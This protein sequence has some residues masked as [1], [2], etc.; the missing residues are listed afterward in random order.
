MQICLYLHCDNVSK[1]NRMDTARAQKFSLQASHWSSPNA[2]TTCDLLP[3]IP[4]D[5]SKEPIHVQSGAWKLCWVLPGSYKAQ[6]DVHD[7]L[8]S[9]QEGPRIRSSGIDLLWNA[10]SI[11]P[12]IAGLCSE[13]DGAWP[14][15]QVSAPLPWFAES[16]CGQSLWSSRRLTQG[17]RRTPGAYA[18]CGHCSREDI[19]MC[20][21]LKV[22][23]L[24]GTT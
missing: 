22:H 9:G 6:A 21:C 23:P 2:V 16:A 8:V 4:T 20:R 18:V 3:L 13:T 10:C 11:C 12:A 7:M 1:S 19:G 14:C 15:L 24:Q 5:M 17:R